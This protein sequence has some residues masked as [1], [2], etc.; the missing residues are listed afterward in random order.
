M[1]ST[2][3]STIWYYSLNHFMDVLKLLPHIYLVS[4]FLT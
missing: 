4:Y 3:I 2:N 1:E